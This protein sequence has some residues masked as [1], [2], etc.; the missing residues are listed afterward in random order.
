MRLGRKAFSLLEILFTLVLLAITVA[1]INQGQAG[2][3]KTTVGAQLRAQATALAQG[4]MTEIELTLKRKSFLALPAEEKGDFKN[5]RLDRF[6]W[7]RTIENVD[8]GCF[9]PQEAKEDGQEQSGFFSIAEKVFEKAVRKIMVEVTWEEG[10]N[11]RRESL[12]QLFVRF[13][14]IAQ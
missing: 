6:K 5:E 4:K 11:T 12:T 13:E 1:S 3:I 2:A 8:L 14:D 7:I 9:I 10:P